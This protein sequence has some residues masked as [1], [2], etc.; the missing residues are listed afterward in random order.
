M[1]I[2]DYP[3]SKWV[4][5]LVR[6]NRA[7]RLWRVCKVLWCD[8]KS[9]TK[10]IG[11]GFC[12]LLCQAMSKVSKVT[13]LVELTFRLSE[14]ANITPKGSEITYSIRNGVGK[15]RRITIFAPKDSEGVMAFAA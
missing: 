12:L 10:V 1:K 2:Y 14:I 6:F 11:A 13:K 4:G 15:Y 5:H 7:R 8:V 3:V 9:G